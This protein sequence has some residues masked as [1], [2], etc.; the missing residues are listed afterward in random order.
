ME[1]WCGAWLLVARRTR[2]RTGRRSVPPV[3]KAGFTLLELLAVVG[4]IAVLTGLVIGAGR[5]ASDTGKSARARAELTAIST[6]LE[7][8]KAAH[9]DYPRTDTPARLLQSLIGR[10]GPDYQPVVARPLIE[11]A[12]FVTSGALDPFTNDSAGLLDPW[13]QPYRYAYK[14]QTPWSN[15]SYVLYSAGPD[16]S[17]SA[18]LLPGGYPDRAATGNADNLFAN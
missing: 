6:A 2:S 12:R 18:S 11:A 16:G 3:A 10:R 1:A 9:G 13:A 17:E 5:R 7:S 15:P 14:S 4:I 8:Y